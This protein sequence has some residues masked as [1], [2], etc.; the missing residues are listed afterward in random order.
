[1]ADELV[2]GLNAQVLM[3]ATDGV[4]QAILWIV[5]ISV[6]GGLAWL[7]TYW[8]SFKIK[9]LIHETADRTTVVR[10][11]KIRVF[12]DSTGIPRWMLWTSLFKFKK[13]VIPI[14][15]ANF[16]NLTAKGK[17]FVTLFKT[18]N[19]EYALMRADP[20][21]L[22]QYIEYDEFTT[23]Q[24]AALVQEYRESQSYK[25]KNWSEMLIQAFPFIAAIIMVALF[26]IFFADVTKPSIEMGNT[27]KDSMREFQ[28]TYKEMLAA[29]RDRG[30]LLEAQDT[31]IKPATPAP[32]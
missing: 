26:L 29:C 1:M 22:K 32:N 16:I 4:T 14:P 13:D 3:G 30:P 31:V 12:K 24:R 19:G 15:E 10:F 21:K 2:P 9:A 7:L 18:P 28:D 20:S 17:K 25:K 11:D 23:A 27:V 6:L 8:M 5:V